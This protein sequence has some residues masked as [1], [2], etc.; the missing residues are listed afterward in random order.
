MTLI[1]RD[2]QALDHVMGLRSWA[3]AA[4]TQGIISDDEVSRWETLY[5][6]TVAQGKFRWSVTFFITSGRKPDLQPGA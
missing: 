1:V 6:E 5:D 3:H 2:P 4:A